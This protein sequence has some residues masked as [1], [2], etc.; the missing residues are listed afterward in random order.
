MMFTVDVEFLLGTYRA[1]PSGDSVTDQGRGEWPPAPARLVPALIA[2]DGA[3]SADAAELE[4][5]TAAGPPLIYADPDPH[6]Q[7][8]HGRYVVVNKKSSKTHQEYP[9]RTGSLVRP[10]VRMALRDRLV[11]FVYPDFDP[12]EATFAALRWRADRVGYLGCADSPVAVTVSRV[13]ELPEGAA[14]VPDPNG[15]ELVNTHTAGHLEAWCRAYRAWAERGVSRRQ[16]PALRHQTL[17]RRPDCEPEP[18]TDGGRVV[19]WV[20][21]GS[22]VHGRRVAAVAHAFKRAAYAL[23]TE[24]HGHLPPAWF[25]GH[26]LSETGSGWQLARFLPLPNV[27]GTYS[28]GRIHGT[29]VWIPPGVDEVEARRVT[30]S[31]LS[32]THLAGM[33][34]HLVVADQQDTRRW[35][36]ATSSSRWSG[37]SRQW[38]TA[39]PAVSDRH[40]PVQR[41]GA[42]D[43]ARWCRQAGLP[44]PVAA[45]VSRTPLLAGAVDLS[46][47]E[48]ARPGHNQPRSWAHV[49]MFF[50]QK[51]K[52]PVVVGGARSY[53][54]G[55]CAPVA[56]TLG[57]EKPK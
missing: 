50:A 38:A 26:G 37:P 36:R 30:E 24:T 52:G 39:F 10:G 15:S 48:T 25:H 14:F 29:A 23:Y 5:F 34:E 33:T 8:L 47:S 43:V 6:A 54:L 49:E 32:V 20:R 40:G 45:R 57:R 7:R 35:V 53:G 31:V 2:A 42:A 17:Y 4:A 41:L 28:D 51:V 22:T 12:D 44:E 46:P 56:E 27:G 16:F 55:L 21:F 11:T 13:D 9:A 3:S 1:D 19:A 18:E